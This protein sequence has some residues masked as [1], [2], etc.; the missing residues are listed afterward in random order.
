M[1]I[2]VMEQN[3]AKYSLYRTTQNHV[4]VRGVGVNMD[5]NKALLHRTV[6]VIQ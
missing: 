5:V 1:Y 2:K 4:Y 6:T 3:P